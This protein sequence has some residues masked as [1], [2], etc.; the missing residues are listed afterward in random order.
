M[1][2]ETGSLGYELIREQVLG[3][4]AATR[5][6]QLNALLGQLRVAHESVVQ[7]RDRL[8][9]MVDE[10]AK[11]LGTLRGQLKDREAAR[12]L[13]LARLVEASTAAVF[14]R[15][16]ALEGY[17]LQSADLELRL[18]LGIEKAD[19]DFR[20]SSQLPPEAIGAVTLSLAAV[21]PSLE[22]ARVGP[23]L[24]RLRNAVSQAQLRLD[25]ID[26]EPAIAALAAV[27]QWLAAA[28]EPAPALAQLPSLYQFL[29]PLIPTGDAALWADVAARSQDLAA[30][31]A[32]HAATLDDHAD[33]IQRVAG[34]LPAG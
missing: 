29:L 27:E 21:P 2:E 7:D 9:A 4:A 23:A 26:N 13:E 16:A 1:P 5:S 12:S 11:E 30:G 6:E 3:A 25:A 10:Q 24:V 34:A 14:N 19:L 18:G 22:S 17:S 31:E 20:S 28:D 8:R 32:P 15:A 33:L